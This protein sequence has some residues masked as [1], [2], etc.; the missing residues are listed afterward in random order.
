[1]KIIRKM[2][3]FYRLDRK[4]KKLLFEAYLLLGWARYRKKIAFAK[5]V[6][7]L[8]EKMIEIPFLTCCYF[9]KCFLCPS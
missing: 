6:P 3:S 2:I 7:S 1:M 4:T 8:G 9:T 5:V